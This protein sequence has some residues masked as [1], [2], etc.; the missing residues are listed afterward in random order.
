M[1]LYYACFTLYDASMSLYYACFT[2]YDALMSLYNL[3][4]YF[5]DLLCSIY[6][7]FLS[8]YDYTMQYYIMRVIACVCACVN[9][10]VRPSGFV[11]PITCTIMHGFQNNLAQLLPLRRR[12]AI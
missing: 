7:A 1:S 4:I 6:Y 8:F 12:S 11:R 9:A 3:Q 2:L 5:Y 10:F